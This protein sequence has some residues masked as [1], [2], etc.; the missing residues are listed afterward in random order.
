MKYK[1]VRYLTIHIYICSEYFECQYGRMVK[2]TGFR[3]GEMRRSLNMSSATYLNQDFP[4]VVLPLRIEV[5]W[6]ADG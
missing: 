5:V 4:S 2:S 1:R 3:T 6:E